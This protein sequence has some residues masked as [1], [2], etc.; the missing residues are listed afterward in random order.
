[1]QMQETYSVSRRSMDMEDYVDVFRRHSSWILGPLYAGIV[2]ASVV[3][4]LWEDTY[5]ST[6]VVRVTPPQVPERYVQSALNQMLTDRINGI[7]QQVLSRSA[8]INII[9]THD[10][11]ERD[12]RN[13]PLEDIVDKMRLKHISIG[14]VATLQGQQARA[15]AFPVTFKYKDRYKAQKVAQEIVSR[16]ISEN[17][18]A[19]LGATQQTSEFLA[20]E[21]GKAKAK[22]DQI[23]ASLTA[24]RMKNAGRLPDER[25]MNFT[26]LQST[27]GRIATLNGSIQRINQ[28]KLM[29]ES[30]MRLQREQ[31]NQAVAAASVAQN[32]PVTTEAKQRVMNERLVTL[33]REIQTAEQ[34]LANLRELYKEGYPDVQRVKTALEGLKRQ[35]DQLAKKEEEAQKAELAAQSQAPKPTANAKP[36]VLTR[37]MQ[38][39]QLTLKQMEMLI[40]AKTTEA[41]DYSAELTRLNAQVREF[42]GRIGSTPIADQ[43]YSGLTR[44]YD[45][46][47]ME[48]QTLMAKSNDAKR[49]KAVEERNQG[50]TLEML[51]QASLPIEPIE[52]KRPIIIAFGAAIGFVLG[53]VLVGGREMKDTTLKNLK[54]VRAYTQLTVLGSIPLLEEDIVVKRRKRLTLLAWSTAILVGILVMGGSFF[55]YVANKP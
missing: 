54:D 49:G 48:Y 24:F 19:Q 22:L 2:I 32:G 38:A 29:M 4:F 12:R 30:Q 18:R 26:A 28:E 11:Y 47:K 33:E 25:S 52:P 14:Q 7:A 21:L 46:A 53:L 36:V 10:L 9:Q 35:R 45:N 31:Y 39:M 8:L 43:E 3:A 55:Y 37:E 42:Q 1:M 34:T 20:E 6:A 13:L 15:G 51:D 41:Q 23:E 40:Q 5:V 44:D 27:E 16:L 50:E 17:Q